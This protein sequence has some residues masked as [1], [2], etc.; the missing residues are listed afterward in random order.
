MS[1]TVTKAKEKKVAVVEQLDLSNAV[2]IKPE[3]MTVE[4]LADTYGTLEDRYL[5][6]MAS[7]DPVKNQLA[8]V[9]KALYVKLEDENVEPEDALELTGSHWHLDITACSKNNRTIKS[10]TKA[11]EFLT[12]EVFMQVA[13]VSISDLEKYL[14]PSQL[15]QVLE[16]DTGFS[17]KRKITAKYLG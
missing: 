14:T 3:E 2:S 11:R 10:L 13:K 15:E 9:T 17:A 4:Q 7:L 12:E 6:G 16:F 8:S 1:I 5:A